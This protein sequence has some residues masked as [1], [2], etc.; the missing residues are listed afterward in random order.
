MRPIQ[1]FK[2]LSVGGAQEEKYMVV[3]VRDDAIQQS[4]H[5]LEDIEFSRAL[6]ELYEGGVVCIFSILKS[7]T[8]RLVVVYAPGRIIYRTLCFIQSQSHSVDHDQ[9]KEVNHDHKVAKVIRTDVNYIT[10]PR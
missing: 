10:S 6:F 2:Y 3:E 8:S 1:L 5:V 4:T 7:V 9:V